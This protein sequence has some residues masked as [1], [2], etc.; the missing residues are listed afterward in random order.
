MG[1]DSS[2][3]IATRYGLDGRGI[4]SRCGARF[5]ALFHTGPRAHP[6]SYTVGT[7]SFSGVK[8]PERGV[9]HPNPFSAEVKERVELNLYCNSGLSCPVLA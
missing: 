8:R 9:E 5:S 3:D 2:V 6:A 7:G 4:K 1:R